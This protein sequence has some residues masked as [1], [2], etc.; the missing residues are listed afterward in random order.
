MFLGADTLFT[1]YLCTAVSDLFRFRFIFVYF[2]FLTCLRCTI[3]TKYYNR[4][5]RA[6]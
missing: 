1:Q 2:E 6:G 3:Q 5:C 4:C